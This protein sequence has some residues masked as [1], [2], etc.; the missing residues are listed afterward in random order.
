[1]KTEGMPMG[2]AVR[3]SACKGMG[4]PASLRCN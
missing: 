4:R 3:L 2:R 1:M